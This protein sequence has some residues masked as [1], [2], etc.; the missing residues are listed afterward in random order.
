MGTYFIARVIMG[1]GDVI[2]TLICLQAIMSWFVRMMSAGMM[3]FY[4]LVA[5][6]TEPFIRPF[7]KLT[8]R[9]A[10]SMGIDFSPVIAIIA[11]QLVCRLIAVLILSI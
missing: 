5:S 7:R 8:M 4:N 11:I 1:F 9:F 10:Y 3:K 2:I 6:L